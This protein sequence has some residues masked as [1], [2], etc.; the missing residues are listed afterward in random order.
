MKIVQICPYAMDRPGGV[1]THVRDLSE[2]LRQQGH[3]VRIIAPIGDT[4]IDGAVQLGKCRA[5][6]LHGTE[7]EISRAGGLDLRSCVRD[8]QAWG[9]DVTHLHTPWTPMMAWQLW[10]GL[11]LPSVATFHATLPEDTGF[12]P[13]AW[14][15]RRAAR[16]LHKRLQGITVPS[17]APQGQWAKLGVAPLPDILPPT[18]NLERWRDARN[19]RFGPL[20]VLYMG[21]LEERKGLRVLLNA[22]PKIA[23][24]LTDARLTIAGR[25]PLEPELRAIT[26]THALPRLTFLPPPSDTDAPAL[27]ASAD[28]FA[29][30]ATGGESF[31]LVLIEAMA[32]G[33]L[34]VAAANAG[35]A[36]V[37]TGAGAN[38]LVPPDDADAFA[39]KVIS[40]VSD[41]DRRASYGA[42]AQTHA[43][44]FD[45]RVCGPAFLSLYHQALNKGR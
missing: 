45:V 13:F 33:A 17:A 26:K 39:Q 14:Y 43:A 28:I 18:I 35:F 23:Q 21:R 31:G 29:A 3:E 25:G 41:K 1:Q 2:W 12:D 8:L 34:P 20:H 38:L 30:P 15:I 42:W 11:A 16:Y 22:W 5:I 4:D 19:P 6:K 36:T 10:R 27:V 44:T 40:V 7:F 9:A 32:A 37:L 24:S